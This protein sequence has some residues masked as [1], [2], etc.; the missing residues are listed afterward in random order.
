MKF[1]GKKDRLPQKT[2]DIITS[3]QVKK[4]A[5]ILSEYKNGKLNL[6]R[7]IIENEK[8]WKMQHWDLIRKN[9]SSEPEPASGWLFNSIANKHADAMDN[10]PE[11]YV[12]P[13]E[14]GDSECAK[15]LGSILPV[16]LERNDFEKTYSDVWWYKLKMGTGCYGVFWNNTLENGKGDVDIRQIDILNLFW[17]GGIKDLQ[18]SRN[19][20]NVELVDNDILEMCYPQVTGKLGT[21]AVDVAQY[22]HD[23][24]VS[25][26]GKSAV[27][28]WYYK[29]KKGNKTVVHYCKFVDSIVLYASQND[30]YYKENGYY[31]HGMYP[32]VFDPLFIEEGT[33]CGFGFTDIMKDTQLYIDKL[34]QII[35]KNAMQAGRR[36]FFISDNTGVNEEEFADWSKEFVHVA[37]NID[38]RNIRE[39]TVSQLD[40]G[41][42]N[43]LHQKIDEIKEVSGNRDVSNGG[44]FGGVTAASAITALQEAGNKLGRDMTKNSY[45][46]F[47]NINY[48]IIELIRQFYNDERTFRISG[49]QGGMEFVNYTSEFNTFMKDK[50]PIF[51][52]EVKSSK[53]SPFSKTVQN[54]L[55]KELFAAGL[56][57]PDRSLEAVI[58]IEMMDFEGKN[59]VLEKIRKNAQMLVNQ[60]DM[61]EQMSMMAGLLKDAYSKQN[62][63]KETNDIVNKAAMTEIDGKLSA[64]RK[65]I[66]KPGGAI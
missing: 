47:R 10:Y 49:S 15:V 36:R 38:D 9:D 11:G 17:E 39:I 30:P 40:G 12:L 58:C 66:A 46:V 1:F 8:W 28:D 32:F 61:N 44:T 57:N 16:I 2:T 24:N 26:E 65:V 22:I 60:D 59:A 14:Q 21:N 27:V 3:E 23:E 20:F 33:P 25:T 43:L 37:G 18:K 29:I 52:V 7:R 63:L 55:A 13:R 56:F 35:I 34:N 41:I 31:D 64:I 53:S 45:R 51:D 6:E 5:K 4:A 42:M 19:L 54:E 62:H 48:M 50:K